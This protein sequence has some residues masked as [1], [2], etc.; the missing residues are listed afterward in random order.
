MLLWGNASTNPCTYETKDLSCDNGRCCPNGQVFNGKKCIN[1]LA[2]RTTRV[3]GGGAGA[4]SH[5]GGTQSQTWTGN[6]VIKK[7]RHEVVTLQHVH[8]HQ[9]VQGTN[10]VRK[11][12]D[13]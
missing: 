1:K 13:P 10:Q 2:V 5:G 6:T 8:H 3:L 4:A 9:D 7:Q 11:C 12:S